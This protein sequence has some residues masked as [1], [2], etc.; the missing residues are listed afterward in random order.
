MH[1][2]THKGLVFGPFL[3]DSWSDSGENFIGPLFPGPLPICQVS[4]KS[5]KFPRKYTR[6]IIGRQS[7]GSLIRGFDNPRVR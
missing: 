1:G 5:I 2:I 4:F 3:R 6:K 7:E